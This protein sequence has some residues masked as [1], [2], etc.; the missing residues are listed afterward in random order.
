[1]RFRATIHVLLKPDVADVQG[2]AIQQSLHRHGDSVAAVR[3]GKYFE[4]EL[5]AASE[6][7]ARAIVERLANGTFSNPTIERFWCEITAVS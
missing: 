7:D 6:S 2:N 3:A 5:D 1:M 4:I